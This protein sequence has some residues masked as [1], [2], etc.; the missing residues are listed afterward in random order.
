[1][2]TPRESGAS[3]GGGTPSS[4][5]TAMPQWRGRGGGGGIAP[6]GRCRPWTDGLGSSYNI[7]PSRWESPPMIG[8]MDVRRPFSEFIEIIFVLGNHYH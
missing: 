3:A 2:T 6:H 5:G 8:R 1:M 4:D 7:R